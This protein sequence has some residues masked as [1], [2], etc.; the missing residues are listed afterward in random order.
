MSRI[1]VKLPGN[2]PAAPHLRQGGQALR[3]GGRVMKGELDGW[4][5]TSLALSTPALLAV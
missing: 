3:K 1:S 2:G 5:R 4:L